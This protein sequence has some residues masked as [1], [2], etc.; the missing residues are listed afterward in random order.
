MRAFFNKC[1][2]GIF[3]LFYI[4]IGYKIANINKFKNFKA[5]IE[6]HEKNEHKRDCRLESCLRIAT[7]LYVI[8]VG[9]GEETPRVARLSVAHVT[10]VNITFVGVFSKLRSKGHWTKIQDEIL[11]HQ[12]QELELGSTRRTRSGGWAEH[13][14]AEW[15]ICLP[16]SSTYSDQCCLGQLLALPRSLQETLVQQ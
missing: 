7:G 14:H 1:Y 8:F 13:M 12:S 4:N 10:H 3:S 2:K 9:H 11:T 6:K 5:S 16:T 15:M